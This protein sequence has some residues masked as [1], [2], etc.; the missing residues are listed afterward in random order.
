M[1]SGWNCFVALVI[2]DITVLACTRFGLTDWIPWIVG[3][4]VFV[5]FVILLSVNMIIR[6]RCKAEQR[7]AEE[8]TQAPAATAEGK[9][10]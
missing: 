4:V 3:L 1:S 10:E 7:K 8:Q 5:I 6:R 9:E 2:A